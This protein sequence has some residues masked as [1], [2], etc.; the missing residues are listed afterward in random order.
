[1][2]ASRGLLRNVS[3]IAF[4][5][6]ISASTAYPQAN[7]EVTEAA[8]GKETQK[9]ISSERSLEREEQFL[10]ETE[11]LGSPGKAIFVAREAAL[12]ILETPNSCSDWF[13]ESTPDPQDVF[14]SLH[15]QLDNDGQRFVL[16]ERKDE[17]SIRL[18]EPYV[19]RVMQNAGS[20]ATVYINR[21]GAFF[22]SIIMT[23]STSKDPHLTRKYVQLQV[24]QF[25][26]A[27]IRAQMTTLLHELA[28]VVGRVPADAK[29]LPLGSMTN[30]Q[31]VLRHC[32]DEI[33]QGKTKEY[34]A[35]LRESP[36]PQ[37]KKP[38]IPAR[39]DIRVA[40]VSLREHV[41]FLDLEASG[42]E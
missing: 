8:V 20:G 26:G 19:A 15:F 25:R 10:Q 40:N 37:G 18:Y 34:F 9:I 28:H 36:N 5:I 41:P 12:R 14:A 27:D 17:D 32:G 22:K 1:M 39:G 7:R 13:R 6:L 11:T 38:K 35:V 2:F 29:T 21:D 33:A 23:D 24:G 16:A 30:T 4:L 42:P 31:E 3:P